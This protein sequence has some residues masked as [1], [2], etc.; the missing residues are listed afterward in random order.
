MWIESCGDMNKQGGRA[1]RNLSLTASF[2]LP[3]NITNLRSALDFP[4]PPL[5]LAD[6]IQ[7]Q[8]EYLFYCRVGIEPHVPEQ[9]TSLD[10]PGWKRLA[11]AI[12]T[13]YTNCENVLDLFGHRLDPRQLELLIQAQNHLRTALLPYETL[14]DVLGVPDD[15]LP[16]TKTDARQLRDHHSNWAATEI[17]AALKSLRELAE[18]EL[19]R[20]SAAA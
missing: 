16:R 15:K 5:V 14:P 9:V 11:E 1:L 18:H 19:Q 7:A 17:Q 2:L 8:R 10:V 12:R 20:A 4:P 3:S 6:T 13:S